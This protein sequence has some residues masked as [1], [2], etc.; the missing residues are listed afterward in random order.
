MAKETRDPRTATTPTRFAETTPPQSLPSGDYSYVLEIVMNMQVTMGKLT[1]AVEGLKNHAKEHGTELK[2]VAK[3]VHAAK[4]V[5]GVVGGLV[6]LV[7]G[8]IA[9]LVNTYVSTHPAK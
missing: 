4:V 5:I 7:G 8:I 3:D 6:I 9:W 1:E 2:G